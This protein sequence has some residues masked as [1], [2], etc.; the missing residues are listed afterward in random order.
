MVDFYS[1][2][3]IKKARKPYKCESCNSEI[4]EGEPYERHAG[5]YEGNFFSF[6]IC[7]V[8]SKILDY[9]LYELGH[10]EFDLNEMIGEMWDD[11]KIYNFLKE[12]PHPSEFVKD[13][14]RDH[15]E[16]QEERKL[17]NVK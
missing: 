1:T 7:P 12:I 3:K 8:C 13:C 9:Y 6:L 10:S 15:E 11:E 14:L 5:K 17:Q 4:K 2:Q 16:L